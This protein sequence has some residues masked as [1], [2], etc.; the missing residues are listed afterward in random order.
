[1]KIITRIFV[2]EWFK[3]LL[4]S[5]VSLLLL[6]TTADIINAFLRGKDGERAL[7]EWALKMPD[8]T[9][10]M[11]PVTC[12]LATL[13]AFNKL[14]SHN[15][16]IATLAA[17]FS[18]AKITFLIAGCSLVVVVLQFANL[19]FLEPK[20]NKVKRQEITKSKSSEGR[21]LTRSSVDGGQFWFKSKNYFGT[22]ASYNKT[23]QSLQKVN[24]FFFNNDHIMNS[25][26]TAEKATYIKDNFWKLS[27]VKRIYELENLNYPK[28]EQSE[29][30]EIEL[31]ETPEDFSEFE[32]DLTTL[33]W[34][35][36]KNVIDKISNTGINTNEYLVLLHQKLALS[37]ACLVFALIPLGSLYKPNR[38]SD[39]FGKNVAFT[40]ILTVLFFLLFSSSLSFGQSGKVPAWVAAYSVP[41]LFL[42]HSVWTFLRN[43]KLAF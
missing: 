15:E 13:F 14:K 37:F 39:S 18:Y 11:L 35:V 32:A 12:L 16:L 38:R 40:L 1:M 33:S 41:F 4:A 28:F 5:L 21:Y 7:L 26:V 8:L 42:L 31:T 34:P 30:I 19:G 29:Q 20:A 2:T 22:F 9:G 17:G 36:L 27:N 43:R 23:D 10:K 6:I 3:A 24:F 25:L